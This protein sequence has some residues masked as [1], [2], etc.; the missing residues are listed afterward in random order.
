M[1]C[2]E[3]ST[4]LGIDCLP[5]SD[6]GSIAR[7][8][9]P[10]AF[11]DGDSLPIYVQTFNGQLRFF[12]DGGVLMHFVGRGMN[13]DDGRK[14]R[15][16]RAAA[17]V[18]GAVLTESG[19]VE[20][21]APIETAPIAFAAYIATLLHISSWEREQRGTNVD[22]TVLID[23]V[24]MCLR[25]WKP[26]A[27]LIP[28]PEFNGISTQRH[29]LDFLFDGQGVLATSPHPNSVSAAI[30]KLLDIRS[31]SQNAGVSLLVVIDDRDDD[32]AADR[33]GRVLQA[34]AKVLPF[35]NLEKNA[36]RSS[37]RGAA[38]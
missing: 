19:D 10:F 31:E 27:E 36:T 30:R 37:G 2:D 22:T 15:F 34:V 14:S 5:I 18:N 38:H 9:S 21:W 23:E 32:E 3:L 11:D 20:V 28:E 6:D 24:A 8:E 26:E 4:L 25:A 29:K 35:S 16:V 17:E 33:E 13:F 7:I 1:I 12:D